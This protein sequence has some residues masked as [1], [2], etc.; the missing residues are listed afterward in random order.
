MKKVIFGIFSLAVVG[1]FTAC[2][3][4]E[5]TE[6]TVVEEEVV[7]AIQDFQLNTAESTLA[8]E[9]TWV[10]GDSDGNAHNGTI[11]V[12]EGNLHLENG[13][14]TGGFAI[15]MNTIDNEDLEDQMYKE[16]LESH[17]K[18][19][20]F[21]NVE[22]FPVTKVAIEGS[23]FEEANVR[24]HA[25]GLEIEKTLP[26][27]ANFSDDKAVLTGEFEVDFVDAEMPGN[28]LNE[29]NPEQG[30]VSSVIKFNLNVVLDKQ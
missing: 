9:G 4:D 17:L 19:D 8:W 28:Q 20:D 21:F 29:E 12:T 27:S 18:S 26:I 3:N 23:N 11:N 22:E 15:D 24:I 25:F 30:A 7:E 10:G 6:E 13:V 16:K 14:Y 5:A 1:M 2:S